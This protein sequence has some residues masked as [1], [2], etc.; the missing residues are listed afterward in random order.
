MCVYFTNSRRSKN[1]LSIKHDSEYAKLETWCQ[2]EVGDDNYVFNSNSPTFDHVIYKK[3]SFSERDDKFTLNTNKSLPPLT[4]NTWWCK[5]YADYGSTQY[6][7][8]G[9]KEKRTI[10]L[11]SISLKQ[12]L[13]QLHI[14]GPLFQVCN[15][16][17]RSKNNSKQNIAPF[18]YFEKGKFC[19]Q[20]SS[21]VE[22]KKWYPYDKYYPLQDNLHIYFTPRDLG[23]LNTINFVNL[24]TPTL[25]IQ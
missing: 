4:V 25:L 21:D 19:N 6:F 1:M 17:L 12:L 2:G 5:M 18:A 16:L 8:G 10:P 15:Q 20:L 11:C 23:L 14:E 7:T 22:F 9:Y 13:S 3:L 24:L